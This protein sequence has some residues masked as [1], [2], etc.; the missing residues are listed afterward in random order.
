MA[1]PLNSDGFIFTDENGAI[2]SVSAFLRLNGLPD[3]SRSRA[4]VIEEMREIWPDIRILEEL[5]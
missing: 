1:T 2:F 5:N 4:I 3:D